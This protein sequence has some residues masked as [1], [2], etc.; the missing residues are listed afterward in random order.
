MT[1]GELYQQ[2]Q[3][4]EAVAAA[5]QDVRQHPT[6][7]AHRWLL[8]ELLCIAGEFD[9]ADKQLDAINPPDAPGTLAVAA[10]RQLIRAE[11]ARQ[12]VFQEGRLPEF[13]EAPSEAIQL[14]L[15]ALVALREEKPAEALQL[16][17]EA[18][19]V[20]PAIRGLCDGSPFES[21]ADTSDVTASFFEVYSP[22]GKYYWVPCELVER[23]ELHAPQRPRDLLWRPVRMI[24]R[25]ATGNDL[26][27]PVVY[28]ATYAQGDD[29][30]RL[31]RTTSWQGAEGC[32][33]Q[34]V[35]QRIFDAG[36]R[37]VP[38]LDMKLFECHEITETSPEPLPGTQ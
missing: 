7:V 10:F 25:G 30:A 37:E 9:R 19:A 5:T 15:K 36:T 35:G 2:G 13:I 34:G 17:A 21:F 1:A 27:L 26:F 14:H 22:S 38:I 3:L 20:R 23:I 18:S 32:P 33:V 12:Q 29:A 11:V 16:L 31:A 4:A 24:V 28:F 6:D 8:A